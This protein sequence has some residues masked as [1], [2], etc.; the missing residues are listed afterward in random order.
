MTRGDHSGA[1]YWIRYSADRLSERLAKA[2]HPAIERAVN[3]LL[4]ELDCSLQANPDATFDGCAK[5]RVSMASVLDGTISAGAVPVSSATV[6]LPSAATQ[7]TY[8]HTDPVLTG[9]L[10]AE[11]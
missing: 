4:Y 2:G 9:R 6:C 11:L 5:A 8:Y 3:H 1:L 7:V 10:R